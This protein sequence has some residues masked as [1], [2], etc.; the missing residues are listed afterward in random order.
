MNKSKIINELK[1]LN[2]NKDEF[3][4]I[5]SSSLVLRDLLESANDIDIAITKSQFDK[6]NNLVY[7]GE[8]HNCKWYRI[9]DNVECCIDT[10]SSDKVEYLYPFNLLR[11][12]YYYEII[13]NSNREKDLIKKDILNHFLTNKK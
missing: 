12:E 4:V 1:K 5:G 3:W 7:L 8:N 10:F 13:R 9:N 2:L 11:L 6:L